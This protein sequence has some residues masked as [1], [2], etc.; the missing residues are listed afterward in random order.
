MAISKDVLNRSVKELAQNLI[1]MEKSFL[2]L[3]FLDG[4]FQLFPI[5]T[6]EIIV[7]PT[8]GSI[9]IKQET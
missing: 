2:M 7:T 6:Q 4:C 8:L 9:F 5:V 1:V 3:L